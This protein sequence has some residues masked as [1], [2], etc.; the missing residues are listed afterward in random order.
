MHLN[1]RTTV[2]SIGT[3]FNRRNHVNRNTSPRRTIHDPHEKSFIGDRSNAFGNTYQFF[4]TGASTYEDLLE[5]AERLVSFERIITTSNVYFDS[6]T[7][8]TYA[9]DSTPYNPS[10]FVTISFGVPGTGGATNTLDRRLCLHIARS[11]NVGREGKMFYRGALDEASI[12]TVAG[13]AILTNQSGLQSELAA[14]L[15][16]S[17]LAS[18]I[19]AGTSPLKMVIGSSVIRFVQGLIVRGVAVVKANRTWFDRA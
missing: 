10:S 12:E 4:N 7:I 13:N 17:G 11:A 3:T 9:S 5:L 8:S 18:H 14:A 1:N 19:G 15:T 6:A 16:A 2:Y